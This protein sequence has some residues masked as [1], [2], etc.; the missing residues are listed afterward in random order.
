MHKELEKID[1]E[2]SKKIHENNRKRVLRAIEIYLSQGK[3]KTS[4]IAEQKHKL[5]YDA[6]FFVRDMDRDILY[7]LIEQRVDKMIE[8]GLVEESRSLFEKYGENCKSFQAIGYKELLPVIR[9][10]LPLEAGVEQ[11]KKNTRNYAKRQ[12]TYIRHQFPVRFYKNT[13]DLLEILKNE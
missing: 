8:Q 2:E 4:V 3:T 5:I 1:P 6:K 7:S 13:A 9:G 12:M 11:I 10:E